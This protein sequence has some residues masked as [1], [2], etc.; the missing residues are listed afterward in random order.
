G[1]DTRSGADGRFVVSMAPG[2]GGEL[3]VGG[4][5][6]PIRRFPL[7]R[8]P[9][10]MLDLGDIELGVPIEVT[11][12]LDRDPG[13]DVRATGPVG[14]SGLQVIAGSRAAPGLFR[15]AFPEEGVWAVEL[16][17]GRGERALTPQVITITQ[18]SAGTEVRL[19]VR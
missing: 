6:H 17:C 13:C 9:L 1:G 18:G 3:R 12:V 14:R 5:N 19:L 4:G 2:G 7:P 10:L 15:L 16:I 11:I 8:A